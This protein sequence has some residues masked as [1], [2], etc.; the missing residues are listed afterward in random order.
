MK[1]EDEIS[2]AFATYLANQYPHVVAT[3]IAN[4][5]KTKLVANNRGGFFT[6]EGNRLKRMG[7]RKGWPDWNIAHPTPKY[8]GLYL[9]LK[10]EGVK[11]FKKNGEFTTP[12]IKEQF[13]ILERL[14]K[15]GYYADFALG[16]DNAKEILDAYMQ[17][18]L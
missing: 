11:I 1:R 12:R 6:P 17:N 18:E 5:R 16:F 14:E 13:E 8:H 2:C 10:A 7:V 3:H 9:E 4:E 15:A